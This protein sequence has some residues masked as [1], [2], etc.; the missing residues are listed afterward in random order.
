MCGQMLCVLD[1]NDVQNNDDDG[2]DDDDEHEHRRCMVDSN[3]SSSS[4][5]DD[6]DDEYMKKYEKPFSQI[7]KFHV[8]TKNKDK[9]VR[10]ESK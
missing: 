10:S 7:F 2:D 1:G 5:I 3:S 9:S 8:Y 6:D 4:N